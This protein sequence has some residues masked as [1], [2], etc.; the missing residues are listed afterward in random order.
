MI[1]QDMYTYGAASCGI[2]E[3]HEYG[4]Q[5]A[6]KIGA[7]QVYDFTIGNPSVPTPDAVTQKFSELLQTASAQSLH[8]YTPAAGDLAVRNAIAKDLSLRSSVTIRG[9]NLFL[10]CGS[11]SALTAVIWALAVPNTQFLVQAPYYPEY[12][13][14]V[15]ASGAS[16]VAVP[17]DKAHFDLNVSAIAERV[18]EHTQAVIVNS[19]NNPSGVVYSRETLG[20]LAA[21][22]EEK[23]RV[24]DH[25]I[26]I[27]SDEPYRELVYDGAEVS[28]IPELY[29]NTIVCYSYSK[30]LSMPGD[31]LG[32]FCIPDSVTDAEA[33]Y[34]AASGAAR[35]QGHICAPSLLQKVIAACTDVR[36]DLTVYNKNRNTLY[37]ALTAYGYRCVKPQGA[38]YLFV[39]SPGGDGKEFSDRAKQENLLVVPGEDFGV[40]DYVRVSTCVDSAMLKRS[41]PVFEK[42]MQ[43]YQK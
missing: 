10:T 40:D 13:P 27:I 29:A 7:E 36:P 2:R 16:F 34:L 26:Y 42:L 21:V 32:Y 18:N 37:D 11:S 8:S 5:Q 14:F 23:S 1:R 35:I 12:R 3:L 24:F 4:V 39:Q 25:P 41:L 38:F 20:K 31:R 30:S 15:E 43:S 28:F 9:E 33:L 19:P 6:A 17:A 22:L